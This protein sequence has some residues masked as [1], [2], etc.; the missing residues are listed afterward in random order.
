MFIYITQNTGVLCLHFL[1]SVPSLFPLPSLTDICLYFKIYGPLWH[2]HHPRTDIKNPSLPPSLCNDWQ[3][4]RYIKSQ[5]IH[6][7]NLSQ[8]SGLD[9]CT[10]IPYAC[11]TDLIRYI[12]TPY[13]TLPNPPHFLP[14]PPISLPARHDQIISNPSFPPSLLHSPNPPLPPIL[15]PTLSLPS[16]LPLRHLPVF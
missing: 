4:P 6:K 13:S 16:P 14:L 12:T 9:V 1:Q 3:V 2:I 11:S 8:A 15:L 5:F 10:S 7:L